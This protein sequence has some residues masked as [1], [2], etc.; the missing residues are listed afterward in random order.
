MAD[1]YSCAQ[2]ANGA[3]NPKAGDVARMKEHMQPAKA[4]RDVPLMQGAMNVIGCIVKAAAGDWESLEPNIS[5]TLVKTLSLL[6]AKM[7]KAYPSPAMENSCAWM[8]AFVPGNKVPYPILCHAPN[9]LLID[10]VWDS[11]L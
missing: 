10:G 6:S 11:H 9:C 5:K 8:A 2:A 4:C 1:P 3:A 7:P